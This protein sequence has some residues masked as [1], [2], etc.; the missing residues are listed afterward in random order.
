MACFHDLP[1]ELVRCIFKL[2]NSGHSHPATTTGPFGRP[3]YLCACAL[4]HS[5]WRQEAQALLTD[6]L[7]FANVGLPEDAEVTERF[8]Q[9]GPHGYSCNDLDLR[10]MDDDLAMAILSTARAGGVR[11]LDLCTTGVPAGM[12]SLAS[13]SS[14]YAASI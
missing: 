14:E 7:C 4:V 8:I 10:H 3:S 9:H 12:F 6:T 11:K 5:S 13:M 2:V 1:A